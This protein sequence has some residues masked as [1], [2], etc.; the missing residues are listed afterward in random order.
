MPCEEFVRRLRPKLTRLLAARVVRDGSNVCRRWRP[1]RHADGGGHALSPR[2]HL[3]HFRSSHVSNRN[4][5]TLEER[6]VLRQQ[7]GAERRHPQS[8]HWQEADDTSD[9]QQQCDR[10]ANPAR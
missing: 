7:Q 6:Y 9:D 4:I 2:F 10:N 5:G 8:D 3:I 1:K